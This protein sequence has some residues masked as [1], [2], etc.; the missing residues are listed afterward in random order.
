MQK[1]TWFFT[2]HAYSRSRDLP[3]YFHQK[4]FG[5]E[6]PNDA[7][8]TIGGSPVTNLKVS[9]RRITGFTPSG[10]AGKQIV[11]ITA[12][13]VDFGVFARRFFYTTSINTTVMSTKKAP[14]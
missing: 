11:S 5:S 9:D 10:A 4:I 3:E 8:V 13:S 1:Q 7:I 12:R 2:V 14:A 6:F